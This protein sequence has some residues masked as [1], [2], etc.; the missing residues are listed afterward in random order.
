[1]P[2]A[3]NGFHIL[4]LHPKNTYL[5]IIKIMPTIIN[6]INNYWNY[7]NITIEFCIDIYPKTFIY[8]K[9][10]KCM[11]LEGLS[12]ISDCFNGLH[13]IN[14]CFIYIKAILRTGMNWKIS[15]P[16]C[17]TWRLDFIP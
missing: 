3:K 2:T 12:T 7:N 15:I 8:T 1:M 13:Y 4:N 10:S 16:V 17:F 5:Y 6:C 9:H 14:I 11:I